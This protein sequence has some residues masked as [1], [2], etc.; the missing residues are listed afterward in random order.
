[1]IYEIGAGGLKPLTTEGKNDLPIGTV[2]H[3]NGYDCPDYVIVENLG[4]KDSRFSNHGTRYQTVNL[5]TFCFYLKDA[6]EL[7]FESERKDNRIQV[8]ITDRKLSPEETAKALFKAQAQERA[9][10]EIKEKVEIERAEAEK[11]GRHF[12]RLHVPASAKALIVAEHNS[13]ESDLMTDYHGSRCTDQ[14]V[15]GWSKHTRNLFPELRKF[16][17]KIDETRRLVTAGSDVEHRENYSMGHGN[18]LKDGYYNRTGWL[19]CKV[20]K[21]GED[22]DNSIYESVGRRCVWGA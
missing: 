17:G 7:K 3:L 19:V 1:M 16:A 2:L 13:D 14:V 20:K 21:W 10:K 8:Y 4:V 12:M 11:R 5:Q 15:L 22:W 18:Y 9:D 6:I